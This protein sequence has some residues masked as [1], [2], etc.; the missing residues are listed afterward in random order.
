MNPMFKLGIGV[1]VSAVGFV[2]MFGAQ[3]QLVALA[4]EGCTDCDQDETT[5]TLVDAV[6]DP[7]GEDSND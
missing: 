7:E 3:R 4:G 5:E 6:A 1:I 2:I